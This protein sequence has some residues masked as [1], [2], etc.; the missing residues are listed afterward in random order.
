MVVYPIILA[1][2]DNNG[3]RRRII[4]QRE[5]EEEWYGWPD[6]TDPRNSQN[7]QPGTGQPL[8]YPKTAWKEVKAPVEDEKKT[9]EM[10]TT[11]KEV[12]NVEANQESR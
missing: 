9:K 1:A 12:K 4:V 8:C 3:N 5:T 2:I 10:K 11:R 6:P 7:W